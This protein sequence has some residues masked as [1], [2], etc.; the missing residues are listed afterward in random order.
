MTEKSLSG[1]E[2]KTSGHSSTLSQPHCSLMFADS[3]GSSSALRGAEL[4]Y[5]ALLS[6]RTRRTAI[7][8]PPNKDAG[9]PSLTLHPH[10]RCVQGRADAQL[11]VRLTKT[12]RALDDYMA[13]KKP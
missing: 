5:I 12:L 4:R 13:P 3:L 1:L 7:S 10:L 2:Q 11:P 8:G 9:T 6:L